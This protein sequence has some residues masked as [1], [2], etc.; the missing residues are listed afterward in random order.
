MIVI[1]ECQLK[2]KRLEHTMREVE[3]LLNENM[4]ALYRHKPLP[5]RT[6]DEE[7]P[8]PAAAEEAGEYG[9]TVS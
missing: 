5:Y 7:S 3:L 2:P 9:L 8:L 6:D 4:L 1:W